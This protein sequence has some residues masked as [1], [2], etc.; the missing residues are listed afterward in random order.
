M[1]CPVAD[2]YVGRM[3]MAKRKEIASS[4]SEGVAIAGDEVDHFKVVFLVFG[5][6]KRI[7]SAPCSCVSVAGRFRVSVE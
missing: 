6:P 5:C 3:V 4:S 1:R 2:F 7:T